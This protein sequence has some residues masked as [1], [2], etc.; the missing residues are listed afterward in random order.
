MLNQNNVNLREETL[1][2]SLYQFLGVVLNSYS[3]PEQAIAVILEEITKVIAE[4]EKMKDFKPELIKPILKS[5]QYIL[6][7]RYNKLLEDS[8]QAFGDNYPVPVKLKL[9]NDKQLI[10]LLDLYI[11]QL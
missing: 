10:N 3:D 4:D 7:T 11:K 8:K 1:R 2:A 5:G 9:D 6:T